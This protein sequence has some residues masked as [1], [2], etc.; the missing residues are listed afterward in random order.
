MHHLF[1]EAEVSRVEPAVTA[2]GTLISDPDVCFRGDGETPRRDA[3][4]LLF[5]DFLSAQP[6]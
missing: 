6:P 5:V 1:L 3:E 2:K 4:K